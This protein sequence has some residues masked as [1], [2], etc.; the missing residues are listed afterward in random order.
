MKLLNLPASALPLVRGLHNG[1]VDRMPGCRWLLSAALAASAISSVATAQAEGPV[2]IDQLPAPARNAILIHVGTGQLT[3]VD[4]ATWEGKPAYEG[5]IR[6]QLRN[7]TV[8]VDAAG[9]LLN[10]EGVE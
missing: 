1:P 7:V 3:E 2:D 8:W 10:I 5:H 9:N 4:E 6:K